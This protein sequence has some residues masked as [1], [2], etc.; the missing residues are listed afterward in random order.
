MKVN[1]QHIKAI[2]Y[3]LKQI[4]VSLNQI[5][6]S[7]ISNT[8]HVYQLKIKSYIALMVGGLVTAQAKYYSA[9]EKKSKSGGGKREEV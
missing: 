1:H 2:N 6:S 4:K 9:A 3:R 5:K 7:Q 8:L